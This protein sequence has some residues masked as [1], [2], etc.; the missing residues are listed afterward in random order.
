LSEID[1][2]NLNP[3]EELVELLLSGPGEGGQGADSLHVGAGMDPDAAQ[4]ADSDL[5]E[6][7]APKESA[8]SAPFDE[9]S[10]RTP[11]VPVQPRSVVRGKNVSSRRRKVWYKRSAVLYPGMFLL[12]M[13]GIFTWRWFS[14]PVTGQSQTRGQQLRNFMGNLISPRESLA[15]SFD[16]KS[17][18]NVI[19]LGL[20]QTPKSRKDPGVIHRSDSMLIASTDFNSKQIRLASV[21]RDGWVQHWQNGENRGYDKLGH[22]YALGQQQ[23]LRKKEDA[24]QGG[25]NRAT[26]T[27][28]KLLDIDI[29]HYVVI[30]IDGFV[31]LIDAMGGLEVDVEKNMNWDDNAGNLHIHLKK[32]PQ[33]LNGEQCM[34][35]ARFRHD[36]MSDKGRMQRQQKVIKLIVQKLATPAMVPRLPQLVKL[37]HES[38][39]T[40]LSP[41]QLL[42]LAQHMDEYDPEEIES[43]SLMS[44]WAREPGHERNLPG[45]SD[46]NQAAHTSDEYIAP[47][48][49]QAIHDF[50]TDLNAAPRAVAKLLQE[51]GSA[52]FTAR[53]DASGSRDRDGSI[54][55]YEVDWNGDGNFEEQSESAIL[56]HEYTKAGDYKVSIRV[57]DDKGKPSQP[58]SL[59][60]SVMPGAEQ[61]AGLESKDEAA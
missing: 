50:L 49:M 56:S 33:V 3:E 22:T 1:N 47:A 19:L 5:A 14:T 44:Y 30:E 27:V 9:P 45:V 12:V 39:R 34:Q 35:Y 54:A 46:G 28:E 41:D 25:I 23:N 40:N 37:A 51:Q 18:I 59:E 32:G 7:H 17:G 61:A 36:A 29:D 55:S 21:P 15:K 16:G 60:L 13:F 57:L 42:A 2:N 52:P 31:K 10:A 38:V 24:G 26:E 43:M 6:L 20:D 11:Y 48:D 53:L 58:Q 8:E 4:G